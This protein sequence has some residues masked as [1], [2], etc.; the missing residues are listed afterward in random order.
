VCVVGCGPG[1]GFTSVNPP[2]DSALLV[3]KMFNLF[4]VWAFSR[5][6][7][8]KVLRLRKFKV[9]E[10]MFISP[11]RDASAAIASVSA[12]QHPISPIRFHRLLLT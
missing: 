11:R 10:Q 5:K 8:S 4:R 1:W 12:V 3:Y 6:G 9:G 7:G 2:G